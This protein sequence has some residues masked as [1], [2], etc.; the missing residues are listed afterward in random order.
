M[1]RFEEKVVKL[2]RKKPLKATGK[3]SES[4][5]TVMM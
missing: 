5:T 1:V 4:E 2:L 3:I